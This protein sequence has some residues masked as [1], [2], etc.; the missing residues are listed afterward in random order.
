MP[1]KVQNVKESIDER[2][3]LKYCSGSELFIRATKEVFSTSQTNNFA[4]GT[5]MK[6]GIQGQIYLLMF[7][8]G[9]EVNDLMQKTGP[10]G[11]GERSV[12]VLPLVFLAIIIAVDVA[13][14]FIG[15]WWQKRR[16]RK[17]ILQ[18][19]MSTRSKC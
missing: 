14:Y 8:I 11:R 13:I 10:V 2:A 9:L 5:Q 3:F 19:N 12:F 15:R 18:Q 17:M 7:V 16:M 6:E 1:E 4:W